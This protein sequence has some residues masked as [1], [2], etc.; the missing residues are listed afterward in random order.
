MLDSRCWSLRSYRENER[1]PSGVWRPGAT[2]SL[3][4]TSYPELH[5][6]LLFP[7][8]GSLLVLSVVLRTSRERSSAEGRSR[9]TRNSSS[10]VIIRLLLCVLGYLEWSGSWKIRY[11]YSKAMTL[12]P[13]QLI[14]DFRSNSR[15]DWNGLDVS[16]L[17]GLLK[18][19]YDTS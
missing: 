10:Q 4:K 14:L 17:S 12:S 1:E 9:R 15:E 8:L 16:I 6:Y 19:S 18:I 11:F 3:W 7:S 2:G 5:N 13:I